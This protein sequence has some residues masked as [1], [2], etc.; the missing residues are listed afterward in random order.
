MSHD[1]NPYA[2]RQPS[3]A[4]IP[5]ILHLGPPLLFSSHDTTAAAAHVGRRSRSLADGVDEEAHSQLLSV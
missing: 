1:V 3:P 5:P 2:F 4:T